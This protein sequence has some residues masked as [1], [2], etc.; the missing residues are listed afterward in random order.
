MLLY[1]V[2]FDL[3]KAFDIVSIA[4]LWQALKRFG[5]TDKFICINKAPHTGMQAYVAMSGSIANDFEVTRESKHRCVLASI[6][7]SLY[8]SAI[9]K[10]AFKDSLEEE[11]EEFH[12]KR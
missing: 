7:F 8:L 5:C 3:S 1:I 10:V 9:L 11:E 12:W 4:G 2:F 6:F